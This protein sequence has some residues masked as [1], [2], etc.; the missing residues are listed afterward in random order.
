MSDETPHPNTDELALWR[1]NLVAVLEARWRSLTNEPLRRENRTDATTGECLSVFAVFLLLVGGGVLLVCDL[2]IAVLAPSF[3]HLP[4]LLALSGYV[5]A[6]GVAGLGLGILELR[7][8]HRLLR[9]RR[10]RSA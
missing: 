5:V 2:A 3:P 7:R 9:R 10:E 8:W 4:G 6:V 1:A